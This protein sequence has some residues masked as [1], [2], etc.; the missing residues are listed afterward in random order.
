MKGVWKICVFNKCCDNLVKGVIE[1]HSQYGS[2]KGSN[3]HTRSNRV[4]FDNTERRNPRRSMF[5]QSSLCMLVPVWR[6]TKIRKNNQRSWRHV[7]AYQ[8]FMP[9]H[10]RGRAPT[11]P[12][13]WDRYTDANT[14][15]QI[16]HGDQTSGGV[17]FYSVQ[18]ASSDNMAVLQGA[19]K[20]FVALAVWP[21]DDARSVCGSWASC[22]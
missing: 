12:R 20:F 13:F 11:L 14:V 17:T 18:H 21:S 4:T 7:L 8:P 10:R 3:R 2:L 5:V 6:A 19:N 1:A 15:R 9:P 22:S 16:L